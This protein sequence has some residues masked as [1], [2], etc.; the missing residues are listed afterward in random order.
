MLYSSVGLGG[1]SSYTAL[2]AIFG[3][4]H[5][6]IPTISLALNLVVTFIGMIAFWRGG[7]L[8]FRLILP[9][10]VTSVPMS[11]VGGAVRLPEEV[12]FWLLLVTL[13]LVAA[14]LYLVND[15]TLRIH[16]D[17]RQSLALSLLIGALLGFVA[18]TVGIGGGIYLV[19]LIILF[20]M[21]TEKE[22]AAAGTVFVW[23]NS[24]AGFISR[25]QRGAFSGATFFPMVGAVVLG[26]LLGSHLGAERFSPKMVQRLLG[27]VILAAIFYLMRKII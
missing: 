26:G 8:N 13:V 23:V 14:R 11:Y 5:E 22:A 17:R 2:M 12:F 21:S 16:L 25:V 1:G 15:L 7:H 9:F 3:M 18:G 10:V 20:G 6:L 24:A 4:K 19:P 27:I